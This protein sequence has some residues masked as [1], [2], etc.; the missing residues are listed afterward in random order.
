MS[1]ADS[2]ESDSGVD[3]TSCVDDGSS[4]SCANRIPRRIRNRLRLE[5]ASRVKELELHMLPLL[6]RGP[7]AQRD[8]ANAAFQARL[9]ALTIE[10]DDALQEAMT[11]LSSRPPQAVSTVP[12]PSHTAAAVAAGAGAGLLPRSV[13]VAGEKRQK[14]SEKR[15]NYLCR[16]IYREMV[17]LHARFHGEIPRRPPAGIAPF[18]CNSAALQVAHDCQRFISCAPRGCGMQCC[19]YV[20]RDARPSP[21]SAVDMRIPDAEFST[22]TKM[23]ENAG[24]NLEHSVLPGKTLLIIAA[25]LGMGI[26]IAA[27]LRAGARVDAVDALQRS[28]LVIAASHSS[29]TC[30]DAILHHMSSARVAVPIDVIDSCTQ[31]AISNGNAHIAHSMIQCVKSGASS[32]LQR[33]LDRGLIAAA[34]VA[35]ADLLQLFLEQGACA[36]AVDSLRRSA[37]MHAVASKVSA[38]CLSKV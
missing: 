38:A 11:A 16:R 9:H 28:A 32:H 15:A 33:F 14:A 37:L 36:N 13:R 2:D 31:I 17:A 19:L 12:F 26:V 3:G 20:Q 8:L 1:V 27:L 4:G 7:Q 24:A 25:E 29:S 5:H 35:H 30:A 6:S 18:V 23:I 10:R 34:D 21:W 22:I